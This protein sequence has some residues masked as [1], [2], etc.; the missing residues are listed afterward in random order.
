MIR[1]R[2]DF[3]IVGAPKA[4]TTSLYSYL[5]QHPQI[6]APEIK[7]PHFFSCPEV[8]DTYYKVSFIQD[9]QQY[10]QL[11]TTV[12][13]DQLA[14][15]FSPSYLFSAHAAERIHRT[16]PDAKII[17]VLRNPVER[18]IS[19]YLMDV[20]FGLQQLPFAECLVLT[21]KTRLFHR[22]YIEV[23]QYVRQVR[24]FTERFPTENVLILLHEDLIRSTAGTVG[25]ILKF[26]GL[27]AM[28]CDYTPRHNVHKMIRFSLIRKTIMATGVRSL[29]RLLPHIVKSRVVDWI[30]TNNKPQ[31]EQETLRL[32][33]RF[34]EEN[35]QLSQ[36]IDRNLDH[37]DK[38]DGV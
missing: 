33:D 32:A 1:N 34:R 19:H 27:P 16:H 29:G 24:R 36:L 4:G 7:E 13:D 3:F 17:M 35:S 11:Y 38:T 22:E 5:S 26:L 18:A 15:D 23:G 28:H 25:T 14:G 9:E 8:L 2:P 20:R 6:F 37:W 31:F 10:R 21:Q 12:A 30:S